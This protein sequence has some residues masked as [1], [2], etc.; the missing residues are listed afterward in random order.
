MNFSVASGLD[1][2]ELPENNRRKTP[3]KISALSI[4]NATLSPTAVFSHQ[5]T[6]LTQAFVLH[7]HPQSIFQM[8]HHTNH[9]SSSTSD[10]TSNHTNIDIQK[11]ISISAIP[12]SSSNNLAQLSIYNKSSSSPSSSFFNHIIQNNSTNINSKIASC[13]AFPHLSLTHPNNI[14]I[15]TT[16]NQSPKV[17]TNP[18]DKP[19]IIRSVSLSCS[20]S[21]IIIVSDSDSNSGSEATLN[22]TFFSNLILPQVKNHSGQQTLITHPENK[23]IYSSDS[24][25]IEPINISE[26]DDD[27]NDNDNDNDN[28]TD[29]ISNFPNTTQNSNQLKS[30]IVSFRYDLKRFL[31][32]QQKL[33]EKQKKEKQQK[34]IVTQQ[35][36]PINKKKNINKKKKNINK[37]KKTNNNN[38]NNINNINNKKKKISNN[39]KKM[40]SK[41][42]KI[43]LADLPK[44]ILRKV[45][46]Y[47]NQ[48]DLRRLAAANKRLYSFSLEKLYRNILIRGNFARH[49]FQYIVSA[50]NRENYFI[51]RRETNAVLSN[52]QKKKEHIIM[53]IFARGLYLDSNFT[54][55]SP[56]HLKSLFSSLSNNPSLSN[57]TKMIV[58]SSYDEL[59]SIQTGNLFSI[60]EN[61]KDLFYL[62]IYN[63]GSHYNSFPRNKNGIHLYNNYFQ[64]INKFKYNLL[65]QNPDLFHNLRNLSDNFIGF[66]RTLKLNFL[67]FQYLT[68]ITL[69]LNWKSTSS[70]NGQSQDDFT[71]YILAL[72]DLKNFSNVKCLIINNYFDNINDHIDEF[73]DSNL[74][75]SISSCTC[76]DSEIHNINYNDECSS[77]SNINNETDNDPNIIGK[78]KSESESGSVSQNE[79]ETDTE[80]CNIENGTRIKT[81][82]RTSLEKIPLK[83]Q[84]NL[85]NNLI[86]YKETLLEDNKEQFSSSSSPILVDISDDTS[87][88]DISDDEDGKKSAIEFFGNVVSLPDTG[89][90]GSDSDGIELIDYDY[91]INENIKK[92][93]NLDP[94]LDSDSSFSSFHSVMVDSSS[95]KLLSEIN[96]FKNE[97]ITLNPG[98]SD[99]IE[100]ISVPQNSPKHNSQIKKHFQEPTNEDI[101]NQSTNGIHNFSFNNRND[102]LV[103]TGNKS[104]KNSISDCIEVLNILA[105][106]KFNFNN[107]NTLILKNFHVQNRSKISRESDIINEKPVSS[108]LDNSNGQLQ[109]SDTNVISSSNHS[110]FLKNT[111]GNNTMNKEKKGQK[112]YTKALG[113]LFSL[114]KN[115]TKKLLS[116]SLRKFE[117]NVY[118]LSEYCSLNLGNCDAK[119]ISSF[120]KDKNTNNKINKSLSRCQCD[121]FFLYVTENLVSEFVNLKRLALRF[122]IYNN[123]ISEFYDLNNGDV[124]YKNLNQLNNSDI[125]MLNG[126]AFFYDYKENNNF[127]ASGSS[128]KQYVAPDNSFISSIGSCT[129]FSD[130]EF[131]ENKLDLNESLPV[132]F[133]DTNFIDDEDKS[134]FFGSYRIQHD[135]T[136]EVDAF[137]F[138]SSNCTGVGSQTIYKN[139]KILPWKDSN[140]LFVN[141]SFEDPGKS[142]SQN[143]FKMPKNT[144]VID[145]TSKSVSDCD[146]DN[147][148]EILEVDARYTLSF[149]YIQNFYII[150]QNSISKLD[151]LEYLYFNA[152]N[153]DLLSNWPLKTMSKSQLKQTEMKDLDVGLKMV[154][155][156]LSKTETINCNLNFEGLNCELS[157]LKLPSYHNPNID[158]SMSLLK[159]EN[160]KA[161]VDDYTKLTGSFTDNNNYMNNEKDTLTNFHENDDISLSLGCKDKISCNNRSSTGSTSSDCESISNFI[162][163]EKLK[164]TSPLNVIEQHHSAFYNK[165]FSKINKAEN[166]PNRLSGQKNVFKFFS[167]FN[168]NAHES[169]NKGNSIDF[170]DTSNISFNYGQSNL[171]LETFNPLNIGKSEIFSSS[172]NNQSS[173]SISVFTNNNLE[174]QEISPT[175]TQTFD[176]KT[177]RLIDEDF[178]F[179]DY[180][181][182]F[183]FLD[184]EIDL[185]V[186]E[187]MDENQTGV[188]ENSIFDKYKIKYMNGF[189]DNFSEKNLFE[190]SYNL[191]ENFSKAYNYYFTSFF[192]PLISSFHKLR[193]LILPNFIQQFFITNIEMLKTFLK[194]CKCYHC[195]LTRRKLKRL[196]IPYKSDSSQKLLDFYKRLIAEVQANLNASNFENEINLNYLIFARCFSYDIKNSV[197]EELYDT[198]RKLLANP[199]FNEYELFVTLFIHSLKEYLSYFVNSFPNLKLVVL[200]GIYFKVVSKIVQNEN[201]VDIEKRFFEPVLDNCYDYKH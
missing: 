143:L 51:Q 91:L 94:D 81:K 196:I 13:L 8:P 140:I 147:Y 168:E 1:L 102:N 193:F 148:T 17:N 20:D 123:N 164:D 87:I 28:D 58:V 57:L 195:K 52:K 11:N 31:K 165:K 139:E 130:F 150:I 126:D 145:Q 41:K 176:N 169:L 65:V 179:N 109:N 14:N 99:D 48:Y 7:Q 93:N 84:K 136:L 182:E 78:N 26:S 183:E 178:E 174:L 152:F 111:E 16:P 43:P 97:T 27:N 194:S 25:D 185:R 47:L 191:K 35:K 184:K 3:Q 88:I 73:T 32:F 39:N 189:A 110:N 59:N 199:N 163:T 82:S 154:G 108:D 159:K 186:K 54:Y 4:H 156:T 69:F 15:Q 74:I 29:F 200:N 67:N 72:N 113:S 45:I 95:I 83:I 19:P 107:L 127:K 132:F 177:P 66:P 124:F 50:T 96:T 6:H 30:Y 76:S 112:I 129:V 141:S 133:D 89:A 63:F 155:I 153:S 187:D 12:K 36:K 198:H 21:D 56:N 71:N 75:S 40:S 192:D 117:L 142:E 201:G 160:K 10:H 5:L 18:I 62:Y 90:S 118:C 138:L 166:Y 173:S 64:N 86:P 114:L 115:L 157:K 85:S 34:K 9:N 146:S 116:V 42:K 101:G 121:L 98:N 55:V 171:L 170:V 103:E 80:F 53:P 60:L 23:Q 137:D 161:K 128:L 175:S 77:G 22:S 37:K 162:A 79:T 119:H 24:S 92:I 131:A 46:S 100:D 134:D 68:E 135:N 49:Q 104:L 190:I 188:N 33:P 172:S 167:Q 120:K 144:N 106:K 181:S 180:E 2:I 38:N 122:N 151:Q 61:L 44:D 105:Q 197:K 125:L 149:K 70:T 158:E